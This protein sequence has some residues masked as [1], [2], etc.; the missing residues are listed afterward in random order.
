MTFP[1]SAVVNPE[2]IDTYLLAV[3]VPP[4]VVLP[5]DS[6]KTSLPADKIPVPV[7]TLEFKLSISI[8]W[9]ALKA[10]VPDVKAPDELIRMF[11]ALTALVIA[12]VLP[13]EDTETSPAV[14]VRVA[15]VR[16]VNAPDPEI[17]MLPAAWI[18]PVGATE[19][20]PPIVTVPVDVKLPEPAYVPRDVIAIFA[21]FVVSMP[22]SRIRFPA[23]I[24]T[25]P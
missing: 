1:F 24:A 11:V 21:P 13:L 8:S 25:A 12:T 9:L 18:A 16:F 2:S 3:V 15:P 5:E 20:P 22:A 17:E 7:S 10:S 14:E 4:V 23:L 6:R 19:D